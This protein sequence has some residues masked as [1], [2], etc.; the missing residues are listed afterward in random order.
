MRGKG[1]LLG[2]GQ[3]AHDHLLSTEEGVADEFARAQRDG[4]LSIC[5][6]C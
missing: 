6:I 5:H 4:L 3:H 2:D 1:Y